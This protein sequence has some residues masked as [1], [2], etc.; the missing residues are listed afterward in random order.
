MSKISIEMKISLD[1]EGFLRRECPNCERQFKKRNANS[2][3]NTTDNTS[4]ESYYCPYCHEPAPLNA[5]WTKEQLEYAQQLA[6]KEVLEPELRNLQRQIESLNGSSFVHTDVK[7][8]SPPEPNLLSEPN[9]MVR[10]E[11]PCHPEE[12]L[13]IDEA[14]DQDIACLICGIQYPEVLV[15]EL[16]E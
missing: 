2:D 10:V 6:Y 14:W 15:K 9:D 11:F 1:K 8:S 4:I 3:D 5:W 13:K 16:P 7:L 12:P